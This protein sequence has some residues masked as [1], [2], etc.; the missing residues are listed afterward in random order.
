[1]TADASADR[2]PGRTTPGVKGAALRRRQARV[3]A[4]ETL[5]ETD[6]AHHA[7]G[8]IFVRRS[9]ELQPPP[10]VAEYARELLDGVLQHRRE[11]DAVIAERAP[12]WPLDQMAA[13][14]RNILRLGLFE[15]LHKRDTVPISVAINEAVELAKRYGGDSSAR[16]VNGVLGRVVSPGPDQTHG[17]SQ[18]P[19]QFSTER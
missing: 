1:M 14:D 8:D 15:G 12:A 9:R 4:L 19:D 18:P 10:D 2:T 5:Y 3:L 11:L 7:P 6:V 17:A 16:F 13:I